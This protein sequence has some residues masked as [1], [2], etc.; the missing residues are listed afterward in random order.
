MPVFAKEGCILPMYSANAGNSL[1]DSQD[2]DILLWRGNGSFTLYEDNGSRVLMTQ[3]ESA[4]GNIFAIDASRGVKPAARRMNIIFKDILEADVYVNGERREISGLSFE[5]SGEA[6][7]IKLLN[8]VYRTNPK[9]E[10]S[11]SDLFTRIQGSN[12]LK[13]KR[14]KAVLKD[15]SM[16]AKLPKKQREALEELMKMKY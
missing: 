15:S 13:Q 14:L 6:V 4:E 5:Y 7:E 8:C 11:I 10:E 1:S 3:T 16:A 2:M 12:S 9:L